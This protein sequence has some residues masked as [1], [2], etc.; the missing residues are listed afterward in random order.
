MKT[1]RDKLNA[2]VI[3]GVL[4]AGGVVAM[5]FQSLPIGFLAAVGLFLASLMEGDFRPGSSPPRHPRKK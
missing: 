2:V 4:L 3:K 1:A 5:I